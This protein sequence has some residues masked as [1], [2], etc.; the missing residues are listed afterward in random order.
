VTTAFCK[1]QLRFAAEY[2]S[3]NN[4]DS[5]LA[6]L[7]GINN[8]LLK[9]RRSLKS[10]PIEFA[11]SLASSRYCPFPFAAGCPVSPDDVGVGFNDE[12]AVTA[13][14]APEKR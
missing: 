6:D 11:E 14:L 4:F 5:C 12:S 2:L 9:P 8:Q 7:K 10:R 13:L 3:L 1:S